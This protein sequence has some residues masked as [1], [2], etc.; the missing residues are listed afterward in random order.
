VKLRRFDAVVTSAVGATGAATTRAG[1]IASDTSDPTSGVKSIPQSLAMAS[2]SRAPKGEL[3]PV[4]WLTDFGTEGRRYPRKFGPVPSLLS[5]R[6]GDAAQ[7][8]KV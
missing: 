6:D 7:G 1:A 3:Q 2:V 4:R 5:M 8:A